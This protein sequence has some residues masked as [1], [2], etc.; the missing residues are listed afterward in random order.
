MLIVKTYL[1]PSVLIPEA[2]LGLFANE[3]IPKGIVIWKFVKG[4]DLEFSE[5]EF[6]FKN[7]RCVQT[8]LNTYCFKE[9]GRYILCVDNGRFI[10]HSE[11]F[12]NTIEQKNKT[13]ANRDIKK[14]EE[15]ISNYANFSELES[16]REFN[17]TL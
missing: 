9:N 14:G 1:T 2:G 10:N 3:D 11:E 17:L 7:M 16:D 8:F 6:S 4:L 13:I 15:I 12:C 5:E